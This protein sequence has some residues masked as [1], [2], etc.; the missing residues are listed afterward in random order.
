MYQAINLE[1]EYKLITLDPDDR[2][3]LRECHERVFVVLL[4]FFFFVLLV[5]CY[6]FPL[7]P[8]DS[9]P[10]KCGFRAAGGA[11]APLKVRP[12]PRVRSRV[13]WAFLGSWEPSDPPNPALG[14]GLR[15]AWAV[16]VRDV[17]LNPEL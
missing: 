7:P 3:H 12:A 9:V 6:F 2:N 1:Q 5:G 8:P 16:T 14:E 17:L 15:S 10:L 11:R 13:Q 4:F